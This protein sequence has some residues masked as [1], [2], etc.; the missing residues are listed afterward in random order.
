VL[1]H[2]R[3]S[4]LDYGWKAVV[5]G[6]ATWLDD[7]PSLASPSLRAMQHDSRLL[8]N[9]LAGDRT[10]L[11]RFVREIP[12][13]PQ[14]LAASRVTLLLN[15]LSLCQAPDRSFEIRL[16]MQPRPDSQLMAHDHCY[17]FATRVL[18]RE[19]GWTTLRPWGC[20]R[21]STPRVAVRTLSRRA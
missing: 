13:A 18:S 12:R 10:L 21:A 15:R 2:G 9:R 1:R 8:L 3:L 16:N 6:P 19:S 11:T 4:R 5:N 17:A 20:P 7:V 14:R